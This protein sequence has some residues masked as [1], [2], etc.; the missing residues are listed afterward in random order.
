MDINKIISK[1]LFPEGIYCI[2]CGKYTDSTRTYSLCDHC[3]RHMNFQPGYLNCDDELQGKIFDCAV[4]AMGYGV[5]ERRLIFNLKYDGQTYISRTIAH[6]LYDCLRKI[7]AETGECPW[8]K[9]D[10]IAPVPIHKERLKE[11]GFNQA[12]KIARHLGDI[13]GI[14]VS[15][16]VLLRTKHTK[17]QRA[18]SELERRE[19][20]SNAFQTNPKRSKLIQGKKILLLDDIYTTGATAKACATALR[21]SGAKEIYFLSLLE[22]GNR[23]HEFST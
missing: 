2:C 8:L 11:R 17:A 3:I 15:D 5:Y 7:L 14:E 10:V 23:K 22:A 1:V 21:K 20:M 19:N 18:L 6:I 12:A 9:A 4:A 13:C 16:D